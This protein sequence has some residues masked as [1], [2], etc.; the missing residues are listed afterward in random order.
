MQ[1][2]LPGGAIVHACVIHGY[3]GLTSLHPMASAWLFD[4]SAFLQQLR[5][6]SSIV[7]ARWH[8]CAPSCDAFPG[9]SVHTG[10]TWRI[11]LN[12]LNVFAIEFFQTEYSSNSTTL[13]ACTS[14][15]IKYFNECLIS[16]NI[17]H[18]TDIKCDFLRRYRLSA[19][20]IGSD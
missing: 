6:D 20:T 7:F 4:G 17:T 10:T 3:L 14:S 18:V 2:Y 1:S 5:T 9:P 15:M 11:R 19:K 13:N 8:H 16:R 12:V